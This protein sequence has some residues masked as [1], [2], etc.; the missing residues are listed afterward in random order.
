MTVSDPETPLRHAH[1]ALAAR[2]SSGTCP[3]WPTSCSRCSTIDALRGA[4]IRALA[5]YNDPATPQS[6]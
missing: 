2:W 1:R 6:S 3:I 4:A 5:A